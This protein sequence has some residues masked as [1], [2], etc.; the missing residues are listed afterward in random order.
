MKILILF[1]FSSVFKDL[2]S[3]LLPVIWFDE[4][5]FKFY[6]RYKNKNKY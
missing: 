1:N 6:N 5:I 3:L 4:V 2:K